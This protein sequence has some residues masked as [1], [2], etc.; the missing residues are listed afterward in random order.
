MDRAIALMAVA[1]KGEKAPVLLLLRFIDDFGVH[2][3]LTPVERV[4]IESD[5]AAEQDYVQFS[6]RY[7]ALR[8]LF[9]SFQLPP[10]PRRPE[11]LSLGGAERALEKY[12]AAERHPFR[13]SA[14]MG[15]CRALAHRVSRSR[16]GQ[17]QLRYLTHSPP[18]GT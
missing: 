10:L 14:R 9:W 2:S 1:G 3:K 4:F 16:M 17:G 12:A 5:A 13:S 6:W 8:L 7:E 18:L 15:S 11:T